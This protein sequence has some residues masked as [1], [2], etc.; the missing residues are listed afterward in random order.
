MQKYKKL[1]KTLFVISA[2]AMFVASLTLTLT[3]NYIVVLSIFLP[4]VFLAT[5]CLILSTT[6]DELEQNKSMSIV[7]NL[8]TNYA[9]TIVVGFV[10]GIVIQIIRGTL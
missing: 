4:W 7:T 8:T 6:N 5:I 1:L 10:I 3:K 2:L 9:F